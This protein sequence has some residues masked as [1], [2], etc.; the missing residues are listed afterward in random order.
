MSPRPRSAAVLE[1]RRTRGINSY[2]CR[3]CHGVHPLRKCRRFLRL[4]VEKR[5]RAVLANRYCANC[6]AHEHS[7]GACRRGDLCKVCQQD[8]HTLLHMRERPAP[9]RQSHRPA[10]P[11]SRRSSTAPRPTFT[12]RE[13]APSVPRDAAVTSRSA[14]DPAMAPSLSSLLQRHS[15][16]V[17][18]TAAVRIDTGTRVFDTTA[19]IDPCTPTSCIDASL[20]RCFR[21]PTTNVGGEQICSAVVGSKVD[22]NLRLNLLFKIEPHVRVR[23]P[24]RALSESL[25][26]QFRDITLADDRFYLPAT[27][28]VV[29]GADVYP[30]VMQPG[31]LK[32]QDGLPVAQSTVFG[33]VLSGACHQS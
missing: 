12:A 22:A 29:L 28:S 15:V 32:A 26:A 11:S 24:I 4:S 9:R 20:A 8:H 21:L 1:S 23:T 31:F 27:I 17:L 10:S 13:S 6:L 7:D 2:R 3:V 18:P 25:R 16:N 30:K 5:L 14:A 33:W 19:L